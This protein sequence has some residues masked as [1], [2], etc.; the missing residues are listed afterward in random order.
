MNPATHYTLYTQHTRP[1]PRSYIPLF[2]VYTYR[3][4][5]IHICVG[6]IHE[7]DSCIHQTSFVYTQNL[8]FVYTQKHHLCIHQNIICV[9]TKS[10]AW[11]SCVYTYDLC[12]HQNRVVY[13]PI[14]SCV[15]TA[16]PQVAYTHALSRVMPCHR[17]STAVQPGRRTW[18]LQ[19]AQSERLLHAVGIQ[20]RMQE[21]CE[22]G[23]T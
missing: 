13:T 15:Y 17:L 5:C 23:S 6:C 12:I 16:P 8:G 22:G 20:L 1:H 4:M 19:C 3:D 14:F 10:R 11:C 2:C 18:V 7:K 21:E 9:Y